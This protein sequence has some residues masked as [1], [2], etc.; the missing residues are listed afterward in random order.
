MKHPDEYREGAFKS[1]REVLSSLG[2]CNQRA[3]GCLVAG[4]D[5]VGI[6]W[7]MNAW[8]LAGLLNSTPDDV[9]WKLKNVG[10]ATITEIRRNVD[11]FLANPKN[12]PTE[13]EKTTPDQGLTAREAA[14]RIL[15]AGLESLE[16][17]GKHPHEVAALLPHLTAAARLLHD[18]E[19]AEERDPIR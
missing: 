2:E 17:Y 19:Q 11:H 1:L 8:A 7:N 3:F 13:S 14:E 16:D 5:M 10:P 15:A 9:I 12:W 6:T 4:A 18:I